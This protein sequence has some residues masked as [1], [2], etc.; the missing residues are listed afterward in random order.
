MA[1]CLQHAESARA[2]MLEMG[3]LEKKRRRLT[4]SNTDWIAELSGTKDWATY[5][6][7]SPTA[8]EFGGT[9][10]TPTIKTWGALPASE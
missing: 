7:A 10:V 1:Q 8:A 3:A 6:E 2:A 5:L 4:I 9:F